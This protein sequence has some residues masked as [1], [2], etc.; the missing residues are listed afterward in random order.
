MTAGPREPGA[1]LVPAQVKGT[2]LTVQKSLP[3][4][5]NPASVILLGS[6][7]IHRSEDGMGKTGNEDRLYPV[8]EI[9][10]E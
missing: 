9:F 10:R 7:T 4:L 3:L 1:A 6:T 8:V 5:A 2:V